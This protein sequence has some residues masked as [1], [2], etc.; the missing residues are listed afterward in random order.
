MTVIL[1]YINPTKGNT[2]CTLEVETEQGAIELAQKLNPGWTAW[3]DVDGRTV[4]ASQFVEVVACDVCGEIVCRDSQECDDER[5]RQ[6]TPCALCG[7]VEPHDHDPSEYNDPYPERGYPHHD[8]D[9]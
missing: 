3:V 5:E 9:E 8:R 7:E 1:G 4:W 6:R 2:R